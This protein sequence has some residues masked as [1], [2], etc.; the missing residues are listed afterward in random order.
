LHQPFDAPAQHRRDLVFESLITW[1]E[2]AI[3]CP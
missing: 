2:A 3:G 1:R